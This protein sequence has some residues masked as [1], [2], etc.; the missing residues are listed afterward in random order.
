MPVRLRGGVSRGD[1][2][3]NVF[4]FPATI[5][6]P[7]RPAG[8]RTNE[9]SMTI[10]SVTMY[11]ALFGLLSSAC[12]LVKINGQQASDSPSK[13][14]V[15][16]TPTVS[17]VASPSGTSAVGSPSK[18][19][20]TSVSKLVLTD[21]GPNPVAVGS[22]K[23]IGLLDGVK[24]GTPQCEGSYLEQ[25]SLILSL[26]K[27]LATGRVSATGNFH[28][29]MVKLPGGKY[30]CGS[31]IEVVDWKAGDYQF[32][33]S[34][35]SKKHAVAGSI[36]IEN[37][38]RKLDLAWQAEERPTISIAGNDTPATFVSSP[39]HKKAERI[40]TKYCAESA[41]RSP[42]VRLEVSKRSTLVL[43]YRGSVRGS[44]HLLGPM[45]SDN[46][47]IPQRCIKTNAANETKETLETGT[48]YVRLGM[49]GRDRPSFVNFFV[50]PVDSKIPM[51][52]NFG[53]P[54]SGLGL[55]ERSVAQHYPALSIEDIQK[56]DNLRRDLFLHAPKELFVKA[57]VDLDQ[58]SAKPRVMVG[59]YKGNDT[60][61]TTSEFSY[62][63]AGQPLLVLTGRGLVIGA[64]G[65]MFSVSSK[66]LVPVEARAPV[67][68]LVSAPMNPQLFQSHAYL[69][70]GPDD[71]RGLAA[72]KARDDKFGKCRDKVWASAQGKFASLNRYPR[73]NRDR[74]F[75]LRD[76]LKVQADKKCNAEKRDKANVQLWAELESTRTKRREKSLLVCNK[77]LSELFLSR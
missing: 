48:Y 71:G 12:G 15:E 13:H 11:T 46:R 2:L 68:T 63:A 5:R 24:L 6:K 29:L 77:R 30:A 7:S 4:F 66:D 33:I 62:P 51:L 41:P 17:P 53:R 45:S 3:Q 50:K 18:D 44:F 76:S 31:S 57:R 39:I 64:D 22:F 1:S 9:T 58:N 73:R 52:T 47:N 56:S 37:F 25:P 61:R 49:R 10:Q 19:A 26:P 72:K 27:G 21:D 55:S 42:I 28:W 35:Y 65:S 32:Y 34:S 60:H 14:R 54:P 16:P 23:G 69:L 40:P 8:E 20:R 43:G 67:L 38:A 75:A 59:P 74:V 70:A 36:E